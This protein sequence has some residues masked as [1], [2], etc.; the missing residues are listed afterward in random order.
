MK[1][2]WLSKALLVAGIA[3]FCAANHIKILSRLKIYSKVTKAFSLV[4]AT[5]G[6]GS[7]FRKEPSMF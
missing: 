7:G 4:V 3:T 1:S 6:E 5:R 2:D